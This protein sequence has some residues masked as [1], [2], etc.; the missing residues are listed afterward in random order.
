[1]SKSI[2][3]V[4]PRFILKDGTKIYPAWKDGFQKGNLWTSWASLG[5]TEETYKDFD[6]RQFNRCLYDRSPW[7][8]PDSVWIETLD[9]AIASGNFDRVRA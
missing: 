5:G 6:M 2:A 3:T 4:E 7:D 8:V 9:Q 1:M